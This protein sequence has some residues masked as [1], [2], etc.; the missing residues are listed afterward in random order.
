MHR[1]VRVAL[2]GLEGFAAVSALA[3]VAACPA[4]ALPLRPPAGCARCPPR[5]PGGPG[6]PAH[7]PTAASWRHLLRLFEV[8]I[9]SHPA[10]AHRLFGQL[11][12]AGVLWGSPPSLL[13]G[14]PCARAVTL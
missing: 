1:S 7:V 10:P 5:P 2:I 12:T 3:G 11:A 13:R 4:G 14:L 6:G 9:R 8:L